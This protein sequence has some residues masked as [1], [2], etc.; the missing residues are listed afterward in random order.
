MLAD[1]LGAEDRPAVRRSQSR[2][3]VE[4]SSAV[5]LATDY[6]DEWSELAPAATEESGQAADDSIGFRPFTF[7]D[8][9]YVEEVPYEPLLAARFGWWGVST[10]GSRAGT[11]EWMGLDGSSPFWDL[12]GISS[13]GTQTLD[14][15]ATGTEEESTAG[16]LYYFGGPGLTVDI[17]FDRFIHRTGHDPLIRPDGGFYDP[18]L[19]NG[20]PG[21]V[22]YGTDMN[23]GQ[24][25]AIRVQTLDADFKGNLTDNVQW[26]LKL[27]GMRKA[28]ARM[29]NSTQHCFNRTPAPGGNTCHVVSQGQEIDWLTAEIEPRISARFEAL[30]IEYSRT[31]RSFQQDDQFVFNNFNSISP[32]YGLQGVGAY[33]FVPEN[34]TEIDRLKVHADLFSDTELYVVAHLGNTHNEFRDSDRKFYGVD[35]RVTNSVHDG[36]HLTAYGKTF[37]MNNSPDSTALN[38]RYPGQSSFWRESLPPQ[39]FYNPDSYYLS[40][41]DRE[42]GAVGVKGRWQPSYDFDAA[43][44]WLTVTGG[45]EYRTLRRENV[46]Y[47]LDSLPAFTQPDSNTNMVFVGLEQ[48]WS[49]EWNTYLRYRV[50]ETDVPMLGVTHREQLSL[51]AAINSNQPDHEDRIEVGGTWSPADNFLVNGSF[52]VVNRYNHSEFVQFDED[53]YPIV[54]NGWYA[55]TDRWSLSGGWATFSNY[56]DQ[57]VTLGREDGRQAGELTAFTSQWVYYGRADV[58]NLGTTYLW[59]DEVQLI[60]GFEYVRG[61]NRF[62]SPQSPPTATT[63]YSDL[64]AYSDVLVD[65]YRC[66]GGF[67]YRLTEAATFY[68]RYHYLLFD[69]I[70][71]STQTGTAHMLLGGVSA[72]Y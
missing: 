35:A 1:A 43:P 5:V 28:G 4:D 44:S 27:W 15:S 68:F 20:V 8:P 22:L 47:F 33:G 30:S 60:G 71:S 9:G 61:S 26:G 62:L 32:V 31:M 34:Y 18:P 38:L 54:F 66:T 72:V 6:G 56:I 42:T 70:A 7:S 58:I 2:S 39:T 36:M 24:D 25:Y 45:Y 53:D 57:D 17:D 40:L 69:D 23:V 11:G 29:A 51:D 65:S 48:D 10:S 16:N 14:F 21:Y 46:T 37:T 50:L 59:T 19:R 55:P 63:P 12:Q 3:T 13:N 64:P 49:R 52:W 67:D 41:A